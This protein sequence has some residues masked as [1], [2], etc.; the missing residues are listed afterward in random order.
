MCFQ[1]KMPNKTKSKQGV[2]SEQHRKEGHM[3]RRFRFVLNNFLLADP[4]LLSADRLCFIL[5]LENA[6]Q[7]ALFTY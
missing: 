6:I 3:C 2:S 4:N 7:I 1:K 5:L